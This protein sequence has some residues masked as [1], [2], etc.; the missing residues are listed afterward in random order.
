[1]RKHVCASLISQ[2]SGLV[3]AAL[4]GIFN[5]Q[6][7][8]VAVVS[9][10]NGLGPAHVSRISNISSTATAHLVFVAGTINGDVAEAFEAEGSPAAYEPD[11]VL[12]IST[13]RDRV[14]TRLGEAYSTRV[15]GVYATKPGVLL[16]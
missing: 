7:N 3:R 5:P 6:N 16:P 8:S 9:F 11:D 14:V 13:E 1:M 12:V 10:T 4:S 15:V 2:N